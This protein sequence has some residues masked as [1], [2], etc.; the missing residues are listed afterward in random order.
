MEY[1]IESNW[2][3]PTDDNKWSTHQEKR[4]DS[5]ERVLL[6]FNRHI[7]MARLSACPRRVVDSEG[8]I[9]RYYDPLRWS[10]GEPDIQL[11]SGEWVKINA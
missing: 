6:V 4:F 3:F 1:R 2:S 10:K 8:K 5:L 11:E 9:I 7:N